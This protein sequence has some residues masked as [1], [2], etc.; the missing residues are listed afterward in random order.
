MP[1]AGEPSGDVLTEP[2]LLLPDGPAEFGDSVIRWSDARAVV[3]AAFA[4]PAP[5][6]KGTRPP[7]N[8]DEDD[9]RDAREPGL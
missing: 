6:M 8:R 3:A 4:L 7:E 9:T 1:S 5:P 2:E